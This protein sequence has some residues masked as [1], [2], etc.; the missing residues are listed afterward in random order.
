MAT[1]EHVELSAEEVMGLARTRAAELLKRVSPRLSTEAQSLLS[2]EIGNILRMLEESMPALRSIRDDE[3]I[4]T[5]EAA[6]CYLYLVRT[7]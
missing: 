1:K 5:S 3:V 6:N 4:S 2:E 7:S